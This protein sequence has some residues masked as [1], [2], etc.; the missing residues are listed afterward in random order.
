MQEFF[1][2]FFSSELAKKARTALEYVERVRNSPCTGG[3]EE[4]LPVTFD[5]DAW[6]QYAEVAVR[7]S[8]TLTKIIIRNGNNLGSVTDEFLFDLVRNNVDSDSLIFGSAIAVEEYV[9]PKYR[10][11]CPY[12]YKKD[13]VFAHDISLNYNYLDNSTEWYH[14]LRVQNWT[15]ASVSENWVTYR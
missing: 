9:Y 15:R 7:M 11:F 1:N 13:R 5:H 3:T 4:T 2:F 12:A 10:I 6:S 8:N 14:V